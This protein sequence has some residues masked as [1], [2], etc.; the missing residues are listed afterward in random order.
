MM[1]FLPI[2]GGREKSDPSLP[3][4][5][6]FGDCVVSARSSALDSRCNSIFV[7]SV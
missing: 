3:S 2:P 7:L 1:W 5:L 6:F 4:S